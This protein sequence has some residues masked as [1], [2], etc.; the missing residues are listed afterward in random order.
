MQV[1][2]MDT[3]KHAA[4]A[5]VRGTNWRATAVVAAGTVLVTLVALVGYYASPVMNSHQI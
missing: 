2:E 1:G 3:A 4:V 5:P